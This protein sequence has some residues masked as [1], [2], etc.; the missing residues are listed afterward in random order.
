LYYVN[1][2]HPEFQG[3]PQA[4]MVQVAGN[5]RAAVDQIRQEAGAASSLIRFVN[6]DVMSD[7][8][9]PQ[10]RS[11]R[12]GASMFTVFGLLAL[13][14][15]AWGL[16]SSLAFDVA[17]R[18]H[19]IGI[20]SALGADRRRIV[21]MILRRALGLVGVGTAV[22][23]VVAAVAAGYVEP[24]LFRVSG[25]DPAIY[26]GVVGALLTVAAVAGSVPAW[27][28]TRIDARKALQAE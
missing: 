5:P 9:A 23:L 16:Y 22:G 21:R 20:R 15:A 7:Y 17:L 18:T 13:V 10:M 11:W 24:L 12:L 2:S 1:Q 25:R 3:P 27:K 19:E 4:L 26:S 6:A 14:V 28:A 8:V